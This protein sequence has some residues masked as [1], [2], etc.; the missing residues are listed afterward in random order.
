MQALGLSHLGYSAG[1]RQ[2]LRCTLTV[3]QPQDTA[4]D[5]PAAPGPLLQPSHDPHALLH[6]PEEEQPPELRAQGLPTSIVRLN[7]SF[8]LDLAPLFKG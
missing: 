7:T 1:L 2:P 4:G 3:S 5:L 6:Q 8:L